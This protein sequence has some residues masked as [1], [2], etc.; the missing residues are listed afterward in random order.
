MLSH[1]TLFPQRVCGSKFN[2]FKVAGFLACVTGGIVLAP[3]RIF[4]PMLHTVSQF[5]SLNFAHAPSSLQAT[6]FLAGYRHLMRTLNDLYPDLWNITK[7]K[8]KENLHKRLLNSVCSLQ[9]SSPKEAT[10]GKCGRG[11]KRRALVF[12]HFQP[13]DTY[14]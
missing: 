13:P 5:L 8:K 10:A 14:M 3:V 9:G 1:L 2:T 4:L 7:Q 12:P 6:G 11:R